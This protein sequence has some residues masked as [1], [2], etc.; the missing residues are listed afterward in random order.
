MKTFAPAALLSLALCACAVEDAD[1]LAAAAITN[2]DASAAG[3]QLHRRA[4]VSGTL[5]LGYTAKQLVT[6][7]ILD[8]GVTVHADSLPADSLSIP[9][10]ATIDLLADGA[11]ELTVEVSYAGQAAQKKLSVVVPAPIA[12]FALAPA[13]SQV[14]V[15]S[16]TL[17]GQV[18]L[19]YLSATPATLEVLVEGATVLTSSLDASASSSL[20]LSF[21][22]PLA[23]EGGNAIVAVLRY[24]G[25]E[26]TLRTGVTFAWEAPTIDAVAWGAQAFTGA[27]QAAPASL[28]LD[29]SVGVSSTN[30]AYAIDSVGYAVD[31][32]PFTPSAKG[33]DGRYKLQLVNPDL[34]AR[35][36]AVRVVTSNDRRTLTTTFL[37]TTP[38]I[39]PVFDC[40]SAASMLPSTRL[41]SNNQTEYRTLVGYFGNPADR[42]AIDFSFTGLTRFGTTQVVQARTL[43]SG[44]TAASVE[45]NAR[46]FQC[47]VGNNN[48]CD[49]DYDLAFWVDGVQMCS[50]A[51]YGVVRTLN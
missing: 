24:R 3:D 30:P 34:G 23:R 42:H 36:V 40:A 2:L 5:T 22:V 35:Q 15:F 19:G 51:A 31:D 20:P 25:V 10:T 14:P 8:N 39:K 49:V 37:R 32:G 11:N 1:L 9:F 38:V 27:T 13:A 21:T 12:A 16:A 50:R 43:V 28:T 41:I 46:Q 17:T 7:R 47:N 33:V 44:P 45:I 4:T 6:L 29:G 26:R 18:D 48:F